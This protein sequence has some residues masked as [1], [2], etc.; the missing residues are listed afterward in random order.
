MSFRPTSAAAERSRMRLIVLQA[1][2]LSLFATLLVR[3]WY[4][5]VASGDDYRAKAASQSVREVVVQP[6]RGLIV[7]AEGRPLVANR[8]SWVVS[9]D[10]T[11]LGQMSSD[12]QDVLLERVAKALHHKL[13]DVQGRLLNCGTEGSVAGTCWNGSPFQPVPGHDQVDQP[14]PQLI[15]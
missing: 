13:K 7:D 8:S 3:L 14:T 2:V 15:R 9:I 10:R 6:D 1:L 11:T 5:Q 12:E 4:L